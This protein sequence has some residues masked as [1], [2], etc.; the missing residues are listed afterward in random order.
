MTLRRPYDL[1]IV[2]LGEGLDKRMYDYGWI[3]DADTGD[4]VWEMKYMQSRPAGGAPKNR[5]VETIIT[6]PA[7]RYRVHY[8]TDGSHSFP[9]WNDTPPDHREMW[10]ITIYRGD[11]PSIFE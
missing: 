11:G 8:Q 7:G 1:R 9:D 2:C 6:L 5:Y 10:G 3:E 4:L